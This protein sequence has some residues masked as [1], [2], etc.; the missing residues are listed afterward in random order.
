MPHLTHTPTP[1]RPTV[2]RRAAYPTGVIVGIGFTT[3]VAG[4]LL[5]ALAMPPQATTGRLVVLSV[6]VAGFAVVVR[7]A[8][9]ALVTGAMS[10]PFYLGF[11][12]DQH[13]ELTWHGPVDLLRLA[14]LVGAALV[15]TFAGG[16]GNY[17]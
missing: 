17:G 4:C 5:A 8:S 3:V 9:A 1:D 7:R 2:V 10:W 14:V 15:G 12:M 6:V 13:G 16:L 11:L